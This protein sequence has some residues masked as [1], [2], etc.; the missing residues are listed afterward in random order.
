M[1]YNKNK[2]FK[3]DYPVITIGSTGIKITNRGQWMRDKGKITTRIRNTIS[4]S[5]CYL[6]SHNK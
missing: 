5:I 1:N 6:T 4:I 2:E 3:K